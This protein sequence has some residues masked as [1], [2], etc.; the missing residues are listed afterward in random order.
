MF[1]LTQ[2]TYLLCLGVN[3]YYQWHIIPS[4]TS[5]LK[6]SKSIVLISKHNIKQ[7]RGLVFHDKL[8]CQFTTLENSKFME[9]HTRLLICDQVDCCFVVFYTSQIL[10]FLCGNAYLTL[11]CTI[12][13]DSCYSVSL[14]LS[15]VCNGWYLF[16]ALTTDTFQEQVSTAVS[17]GK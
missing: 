11:L 15:G 5:T 8:I 9:E 7:Q 4:F 13:Y 3:N 6:M 2:G 14:L 16:R 1:K 12:I 10:P 17:Y